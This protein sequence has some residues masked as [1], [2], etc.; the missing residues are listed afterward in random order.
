MSLLFD[1]LYLFAW[2]VL[3]PRLLWRALRTGR[4][5]AGLR[6]KI[7]GLSR[8]LPRGAVWF[9]GVSVGEVH[10]LRPVVAEFRRR[11]PY[12][13]CVLSTTTDAGFSEAVRCFPDLAVFRFPFDFSWAVRR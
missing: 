9:H 1:V 5:R 7:L 10:L 4:Y 3:S 13:T 2:L 6:D 12:R 8:P 11:R